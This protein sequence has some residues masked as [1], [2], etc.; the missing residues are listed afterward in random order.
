MNIFV[1]ELPDNCSKCVFMENMSKHWDV[2]DYC[3]LNKLLIG[4]F[5][6]NDK[7]PLKVL[8]HENKTSKQ[9]K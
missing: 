8:N 7:C 3:F 5:E 4:R 6:K 1:D 9:R 2:D